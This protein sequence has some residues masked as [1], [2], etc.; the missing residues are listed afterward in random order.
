[1]ATIGGALAE[2]TRRLEQA[3][4]AD[5]AREA[6]WLLAHVTHTAVG[7]LRL[8]PNELV[9]P[10][11]MEA[12]IGLVMRRVSREPIQYL[13]GTEEFLGLTFKV[14]PAV[15]IP[16]LDTEVLVRQAAGRLARRPV[17]VADIGTGSGAIAV[18]L[19]HLLPGATVLA[20]E[21]SPGALGVAR[22]N[23]AR[24]G[25]ADRVEFRQ[26]DLLAPLRGARF[27]AIISNPPYI[28]EAE[29]ETLMPEVRQW[30][31]KGALTP[32][33]DGLAL[34]RRLAAGAP[35]LLEP[36]GFLAVEVG[37]RQ[38]GA[39]AALFA[40]AGLRTVTHC[41]TAGI[42]RVVVGEKSR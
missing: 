19:A 24:N 14:T 42:E 40:R 15:L 20:T 34:Y 33:A 18:G 23:A 35:S 30:E 31:P 8:V 16:R 13:L 4:V 17:W 1:V 28:D 6:G 27:D 22:E 32:G 9:P 36:G 5:A 29:W 7:L 21:I 37:H 38:A 2:A 11:T 12:Y 10:I 41:D 25:V 39:V 3:G 26:G